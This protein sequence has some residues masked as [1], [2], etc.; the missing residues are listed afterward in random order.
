MEL[1]KEALCIIVA[2]GAAKLPEV[3]FGSTEK[4]PASSPG[5]TPFVCCFIKMH[6]FLT[7]L[8]FVL[9]GSGGGGWARSRSA[10]LV[11][12][13]VFR[14]FLLLVSSLKLGINITSP[15][16]CPLCAFYGA[17]TQCC[18]FYSLG[19]FSVRIRAVSLQ[20]RKSAQSAII[21]MLSATVV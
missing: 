8:H 2:Q 16:F 12:D 18:G 11:N 15:I 3:N 14:N 5:Y 10:L 20:H 7:A 17:I 19:F 21:L 4:K 13:G 9:G 1:S 6:N